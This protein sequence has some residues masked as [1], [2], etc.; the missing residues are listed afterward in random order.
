MRQARSMLGRWHA[1]DSYHEAVAQ[2]QAVQQ[3]GAGRC[4][5]LA[6]RTGLAEALALVSAAC[7]VGLPAVD[8]YERVEPG[9]SQ[10]G[11][12]GLQT[13]RPGARA[14]AARSRDDAPGYMT[15]NGLGS[16]EV[17]AFRDR[18]GE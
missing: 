1:A 4:L 8:A 18:T 11:N 3:A 16:L 14:P 12:D 7:A 9:P 5:D 13:Q 6:G 2:A 10:A 15:R 17:G